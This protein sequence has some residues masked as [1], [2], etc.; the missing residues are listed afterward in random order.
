MTRKIPKTKKG[1][2]DDR[3]AGDPSR[4][5]ELEGADSMLRCYNAAAWRLEDWFD[6][7]PV[8]PPAASPQ[9]KKSGPAPL[10]SPVVK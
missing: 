7:P 1:P 2:G 3:I 10:R 6:P 8:A 9:K 4:Q 5:P